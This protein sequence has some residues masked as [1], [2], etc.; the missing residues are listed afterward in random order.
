MQYAVCCVQFLVCSVQSAV[1]SVQCAVCIVH[2]AVQ[3]LREQR[4]EGEKEGQGG[5][6][7]EGGEKGGRREGDGLSTA[8][9]CGAGAADVIIRV[10]SPCLITCLIVRH[11]SP[12]QHRTAHPSTAH[13]SQPVSE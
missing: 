1:F 13:P 8:L 3:S 7:G 4:E 12:S 5:E 6:E 10:L 11:I 9:L 2:C